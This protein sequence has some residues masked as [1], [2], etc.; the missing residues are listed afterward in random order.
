M[1]DIP[2]WLCTDEDYT[3]L[4]DN[5]AFVKKSI[6][7]I[8][9]VLSKIKRVNNKKANEVNTSLRLFGVFLAIVLTS[10]SRNYV[11]TYLMISLCVLRGAFMPGEK[12][13]S[14]F[15]ILLP[16]LLFSAIIL[17]PAVFLGSPK[18][19]LTILGKIFVAVSLVSILNLTSSP[20]EIISS[21]KRFHIPDLVIYVFDITIKYIYI[22]GTVCLNMLLALKIRSIGKNKT[23]SASASGILGSVFLKSSDYA[24]MTSKAMECRG[25]NGEYIVTKKGRGF[26]KNDCL[27]SL[28]CVIICVAFVYLEVFV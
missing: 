26:T 25:F 9:S 4:K 17:I 11:F 18:T 24:T 12:I 3:P 23:K 28:L 2:V 8:M 14:W 21:L 6:K 19:L 10:L 22:L 16:A 27:F 1:T 5:N 13:K 7:A 20:N 15:K